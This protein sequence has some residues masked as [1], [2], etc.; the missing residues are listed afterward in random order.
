MLASR[1]RILLASALNRHLNSR[2]GAQDG[3][4]HQHMHVHTLFSFREGRGRAGE[5][6]EQAVGRQVGLVGWSQVSHQL[7]TPPTGQASPPANSF[8]EI[9]K[10][11]GEVPVCW[12][13]EQRSP[14]RQPSSVTGGGGLASSHVEMRITR[15]PNL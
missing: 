5:A 12:W 15:R 3:H 10:G 14:E 11:L 13:R 4:A 9:P 2:L 7:V 1:T 8:L 6:T